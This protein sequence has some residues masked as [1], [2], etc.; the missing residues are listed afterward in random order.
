MLSARRE[1][2]TP[3]ELCTVNAAARCEFPFSFGWQCL[4][5]PLR[6]GERI[7]YAMCTTGWLSS[8]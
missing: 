4:A 6:V 7:R 2:V 5:G 3:S 8:S 1:F